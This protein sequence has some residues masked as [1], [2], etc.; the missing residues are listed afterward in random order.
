MKTRQVAFD[1]RRL[2]HWPVEGQLRLPPGL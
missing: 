1:S 2:H